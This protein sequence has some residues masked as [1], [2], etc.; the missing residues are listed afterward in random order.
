MFSD[1]QIFPEA[2]SSIAARVDAL[3]FFITAV[4]LFFFTLIVVLVLVF[5]IKYRRRSE[6]D[7]PKPIH[8]SLKLEL[9]WTIIPLILAM[10]MFIWGAKLY[11]EMFTP[12]AQ[13][14]NIYV[15]G[16]QWMWK[17]QHPEGNREINELHVPVGTPIKLI[18]TSEDVIHSFFVPAFRIKMDVLPG[19]Y[20]SAWF[21]AIKPGKYHLFCAEYCGTKHSEMIGWIYAMEPTEYQDWLSRTSGNT[22]SMAEEGAGLFTQLG[23]STCHAADSGARGPHLAGL[24]GSAVPLLTGKTTVADDA[25]IRRSI[26]EP[27]SEIT[28]G[29]APL[30]PTYEGQVNEEELLKLIAYIK[31]LALESSHSEEN[32]QLTKGT[33]EGNE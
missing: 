7:Q 29:F 24:Y 23:C 27:A 16:K 3:Y 12:P 20:T 4:S 10:V 33:L 2:A 14:L 13:A 6:E 18:M 32:G 26:L 19:R 1:F 17:I 5:A 25:Y 31:S 21:E 15:V 11:V 30:M 22:A 8:G 9:L 28:S